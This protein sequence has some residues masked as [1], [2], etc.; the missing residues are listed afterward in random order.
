MN[1]IKQ[2]L[3]GSAILLG[4]ASLA[5][6]GDYSP[7]SPVR[8]SAGWL[9]DYLRKDDPYMSAW[10]LGAQLR[11][12]YEV[13]EEFGIAGTAGSQDFLDHG[14][15]VDNSFLMTRIRPRVGY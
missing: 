13:R 6:A 8:P 5:N 4:T 11:L 12:R 1:T 15:P 3:S 9:N 2:L 14:A 7:T 10:D